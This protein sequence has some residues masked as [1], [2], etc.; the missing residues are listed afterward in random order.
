[1]KNREKLLNLSI[2]DLMMNIDKRDECAINA[3][4]GN[5]TST[6]RLCD[7]QGCSECI[8]R[9]LNDEAN[10]EDWKPSEQEE[11]S[12]EELIKCIRAY[13]GEWESWVDLF[14]DRYKALIKTEE[15]QGI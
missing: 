5:T 9:W 12:L 11:E 10:G 1:M 4:T 8:E 2:Y 14:E 15:E 6:W 7:G 13:Y 3:V